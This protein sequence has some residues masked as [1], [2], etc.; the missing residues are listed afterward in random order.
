MGLGQGEKVYVV[1][2]QLGFDESLPH[3]WYNPDKAKQL[4]KE[5]GRP[6]GIDVHMMVHNRS[7][8][9]QQAQVFKQMWDVVG[10]RTVLEIAERTANIAKREAGLFEFLAM[11]RSRGADPDEAFSN[12]W[13]CGGAGNFSRYCSRQFDQCLIDARAT[14]DTKQRHDLYKKCQTILY[15]DLP[16]AYVWNMP[17]NVVF[18]KKVKGYVPTYIS[19]DMRAVWMEK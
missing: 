3:Y 10:I 11:N 4:L 19:N 16:Y 13:M 2:G 1:K 9:T 14:Y 12:F 6:D 18:N 5:A 17:N 7:L 15:E 8:D